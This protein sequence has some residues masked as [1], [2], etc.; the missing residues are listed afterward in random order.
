MEFSLQGTWVSTSQVDSKST[1]FISTEYENLFQE[2]FGTK[3][4][5]VDP[6]EVSVLHNVGG[7]GEEVLLMCK[8]SHWECRRL[9]SLGKLNFLPTSDGPLFCVAVNSDPIFHAFSILMLGPRQGF[10][11]VE[12]YKLS[13]SGLELTIGY[14]ITTSQVK[15]SSH[16]STLFLLFWNTVWHGVIFEEIYAIECETIDTNEISIYKFS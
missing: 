8:T 2:L 10:K 12:Q 1:P 14:M 7:D 9:I 6:I 13:A 4:P 16:H 11:I 5:A 15:K 3:F